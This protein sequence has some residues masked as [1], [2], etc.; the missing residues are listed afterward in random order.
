MQKNGIKPSTRAGSNGHAGR[1]CYDV[2]LEQQGGQ[3]QKQQEVDTGGP[4]GNRT[5]VSGVRGQR[6]RPLDDGT[7]RTAMRKMQ[8]TKRGAFAVCTSL[9]I[10]WG[11]R[12]RTPVNRFRACRPTTGR[13]PS[14][15]GACTIYKRGRSVKGK[16][17]GFSVLL[18]R[19]DIMCL[20]TVAASC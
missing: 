16:K 8:M 18:S 17:A 5:R 7:L 11:R 15:N 6:P 10:G 2:K 20:T 3:R 4:N 19:R 14:A 1:R 13:S 9:I 12:I